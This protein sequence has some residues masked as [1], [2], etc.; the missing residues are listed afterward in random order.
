ML[1]KFGFLLAIG[2]AAAGGWVGSASASII[3]PPSSGQV[4]WLAADSG[5]TT[6]GGTVTGWVDSGT[7]AERVNGTVG[8]PTP[9]NVS[10]GNGNHAVVS[11]SGLS[12]LSITNGGMSQQAL[13]IFVVASNNADQNGGEFVT[14]YNNNGNSNGWAVGNADPAPDAGQ[15]KWFS[16]PDGNGSLGNTTGLALTPG[17][18]YI[19]NATIANTPGAVGKTASTFDGTTL[20]GPV[21]DGVTSIPYSGSELGGIGFLNAFG[22]AQFLNGK[23]A[24][25]LV[26]D[27]TGLTASQIAAEQVAVG[28]YLYDKYFAVV[29]EPS[30]VISL[31]LGGVALVGG[32]LLRRRK[33]RSA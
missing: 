8:T 7:A 6:T 28:T 15:V 22:G 11:F 13:D 1:R 9:G 18:Y 24:E 27:N 20:N 4:L 25:V 31:A 33:V 10:F 21:S 32:S 29:P 26:Y 3:P 16:G 19:I 5:V 17:S 14:N 23:I 2:L 12:G 30:S